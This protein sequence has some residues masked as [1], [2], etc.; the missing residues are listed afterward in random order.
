LLGKSKSKSKSK[1][2]V[3]SEKVQQESTEN[4]IDNPSNEVGNNGAE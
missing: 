4:Q 1:S 3:K 2:K